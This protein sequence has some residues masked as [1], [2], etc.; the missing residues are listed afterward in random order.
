MGSYHDAKCIPYMTNI[1]QI[2]FAISDLRHV[3]GK[4]YQE[5]LKPPYR[6]TA[7]FTWAQDPPFRPRHTSP[8]K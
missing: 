7:R 2:L 8:G 4:F 5:G 6:L 3:P 1:G